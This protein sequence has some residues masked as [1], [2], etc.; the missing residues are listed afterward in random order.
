MNNQWFDEIYTS[1]RRANSKDIAELL[2]GL[3]F[4]LS[5][6]AK[7]RVTEKTQETLY[8]LKR[9]YS[10]SQHVIAYYLIFCIGP[11]V[12]GKEVREKLSKEY[13]QTIR[14]YNGRT[15]LIQSLDLID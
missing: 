4:S 9:R 15:D 14:K 6:R 2:K 5:D 7:R 10:P 8:Q 13:E 3:D 11:L 1:G 12:F